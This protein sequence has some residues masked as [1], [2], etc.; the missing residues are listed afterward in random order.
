MSAVTS[1]TPYGD[2]LFGSIDDYTVGSSESTTSADT[3]TPATTKDMF[4]K[5]LVAQVKNQDPLNPADG[6]EFL[7]QLAQ[8][9]SLEQMIDM[10]TQLESIQELV[11]GMQGDTT[12]GAEDGQTDA[13]S[14]A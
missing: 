5:L 9:S 4:L 12:D 14:G 13:A 6:T 2:V 8:F 3:S 11:A 7:A 1:T 10:N